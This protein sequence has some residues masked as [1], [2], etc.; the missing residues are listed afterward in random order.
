MDMIVKHHYYIHFQKVVKFKRVFIS[1]RWLNDVV[2]PAS[3]QFAQ[4]R[5]L[6]AQMLTD[7]TN[8]V[9]G[10]KMRKTP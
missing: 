1:V 3:I 6:L 4:Q 7:T 5:P 8:N 10:V 9:G 2:L